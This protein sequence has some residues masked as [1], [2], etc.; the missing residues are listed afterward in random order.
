MN[1]DE[2]DKQ[3]EE[4]TDDGYYI[5]QGTGQELIVEVNMNQAI[6]YLHQRDAATRLQTLEEVE[7]ELGELPLY[8]LP[9]GMVQ[10]Y[11]IDKNGVKYVGMAINPTDLTNAITKLKG[12]V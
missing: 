8:Q 11:G 1:Q 12:E 10:V 7:K 4:I 5:G 9:P 2:W 6:N 3:F